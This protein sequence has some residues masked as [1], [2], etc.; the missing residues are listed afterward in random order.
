MAMTKR[1]FIVKGRKEAGLL[2]A[3]GG[4][5]QH[6]GAHIVDDP[7]IGNGH[8]AD[9]GALV[10]QKDTILS[11]LTIRPAIVDIARHIKCILRPGLQIVDNGVRVIQLHQPETFLRVNRPYDNGKRRVLNQCRNRHFGTT[12]AFQCRPIDTC[13]DRHYDARH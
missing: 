9:I 1:E 6:A 12:D 4:A 11:E 7:A 10:D 8:M 3:L 5:L 13:R 2:G